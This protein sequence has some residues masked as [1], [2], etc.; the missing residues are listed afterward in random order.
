MEMSPSPSE[1]AF[2]QKVVRSSSDISDPSSAI[3]F[4]NYSLDI[5]P[6]VSLPK[7]ENAIYTYSSYS[8]SVE[9]YLSVVSSRIKLWIISLLTSY[10][11]TASSFLNWLISS[12]DGEMPSESMISSN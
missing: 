9:P 8:S 6:L 2:Y 4:L 11:S 7:S 5:N 10:E 12:W 3:T 1:S